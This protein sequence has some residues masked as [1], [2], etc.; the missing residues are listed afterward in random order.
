MSFGPFGGRRCDGSKD[1]MSRRTT[2]FRLGA[3]DQAPRL[4]YRAAL[5][6]W[7]MLWPCRACGGAELPLL[8]RPHA[9]DLPDAT[10]ELR[11][12]ACPGCE[13]RRR[14]VRAGGE[15]DVWYDA[16]VTSWVVRVEA[17]G[18]RASAI[19]PLEIPWFDAPYAVIDQAAADLLFAGD[20]LCAD[21][22]PDDQPTP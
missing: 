9:D 8:A 21:E 15:P 1:P 11:A 13:T 10:S 7:S 19:L 18:R 3:T 22:E 14:R 17:P 20:A 12:H 2:P 5:D 4:C 16:I 6:A